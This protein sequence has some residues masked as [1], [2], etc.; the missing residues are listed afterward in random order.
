[1]GYRLAEY[2]GRKTESACLSSQHGTSVCD[3]CP[4]FAQYRFPVGQATLG[5][6]YALGFEGSGRPGVRR[7][8]GSWQ[9]LVDEGSPGLPRQLGGSAP[10]VGCP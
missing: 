7:G 9:H 8:R 10:S 6:G 1:M 3:C 4:G 5:G 2:F